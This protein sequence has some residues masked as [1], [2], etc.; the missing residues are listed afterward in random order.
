MSR[1]CLIIY[2]IFIAASCSWSAGA[3]KLLVDHTTQ[4]NIVFCITNSTEYSVY[5]LP[6]CL[7]EQL[8][9]ANL[10][11]KDSVSHWG[12]AR[13]VPLGDRRNVIAV[14]SGKSITFP[15]NEYYGRRWRITCFASTNLIQLEKSA[16]NSNS[17]S[18]RLELHSIEFPPGR[19][20]L[21]NVF[22]VQN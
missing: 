3:I 7:P 1:N 21:T 16:L 2:F 10:N 4:T 5:I 18:N 17:L 6:I 8:Y 13:P 19:F 22:K 9:A 14:N 15:F 12:A 20:H 11:D